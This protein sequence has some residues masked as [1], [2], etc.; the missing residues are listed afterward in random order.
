VVY[1]GDELRPGTTAA[2]TDGGALFKFVPS[3]LRTG[4]GAIT[5]L[6][7]SP[8]IAG[9]V[10]AL[11]VSCVN[12]A[13][14]Y[15]QG[16][17]IGNGRWIPIADATM[18]RALAN[19]SGATG[20]YRPEDL[21]MDPDFTGTG[22]RFCFANTGNAGAANY[23]EVLCATDSAPTTAPASRS[24]VINRFLEGDTQ[25]NAPDNLA[26]LPGTGLLYVIEDNPFGDVWACLPDG[27]DRDIK[28]DGCVRMLSVTDQTAE[29]TGFIFHPNGN[30]A[31]VAIQHSSDPAGALV[32]DFNTDDVLEITGFAAVTPSTFGA[33]VEA[34]LLGDVTN[35][36]GF[37][38]RLAASSVEDY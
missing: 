36:F 24:V 25:L 1:G 11:Q 30:T 28:S 34:R 16:C 5:A 3:V 38:G 19:T 20:Y 13:Q 23:G 7:Q 37:D 21:H 33:S 14:Q 2:D 35:L 29:P 18:A 4:T 15:G 8:F 12:N 9:S 26:F 27:A 17:E 10:Y 22:A 31:Y 32:S 6:S